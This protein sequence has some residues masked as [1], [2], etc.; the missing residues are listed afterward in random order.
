MFAQFL[1]LP[2]SPS[3][4]AG[5]FKIRQIPL[6][7]TNYHSL[8]TTVYGR[9]RDGAKLYVYVKGG[10]L[11]GRKYPCIQELLHIVNSNYLQ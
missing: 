1:I 5:Q 9:I 2:I 6:S 10:K 4:S 8:N 7:Q 3:L 11:Y